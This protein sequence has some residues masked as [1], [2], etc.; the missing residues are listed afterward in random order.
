MEDNLLDNNKLNLKDSKESE[1]FEKSKK[2]FNLNRTLIVLVFGLF[3]LVFFLAGVL[4]QEKRNNEFFTQT[5]RSIED[6]LESKDDGKE[7]QPVIQQEEAVMRVVKEV[8]P[9]V[10]SIV[11][12]KD[13]PVLRRRFEIHG[14]L[15]KIPLYEE[16]DFERREIGGGSGFI[17][18]SQGLILTNRHVVKEEEAEYTVFTSDGKEYK[19][20]VIARDPVQ[21]LAIMEIKE[22]GNFSTVKL[23]SSSNA[24]IGQTVVAIGNAL[25]EFR[26][27]VS[28][29]VVS[30]LGRT[31]TATDGRM[32]YTFEDVI[33]T[34]AAINVG[35]S[36]GPLLNLKGEVI[37]INSAMAIGAQN[38]GFS[39]PI[40][41]AKKMIDN[42]L[43]HGEIVYPFLGVRYLTVNEEVQRR[44]NLPV[45]YGS[46]IIEGDF[47]EPAIDPGSA[48]EK[49]GLR[50]D[51]IILEFDGKKISRENS[52]AQIIL[53]YNPGDK[54]SLKILRNEREIILEA[55]L[56][57][58]SY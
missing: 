47:G 8:S 56:G 55:T 51:D 14:D 21:D 11:V 25:G 45:D 42:F 41:K 36:G 49:A 38:I 15:F 33:Q 35:N 34:D 22:K 16:N 2:N 7:Y 58:K 17:V 39:I 32:M 27:T 24:T 12:S 13:V 6:I 50:K 28:T 18:S 26:N 4:F 9:A 23:G 46:W 1:E 5:P 10:V 53:D 44:N 48:A 57:K 52:L 20:D 43:A 30:G 19:A 31:V 29:G 40:D 3:G 37:G 54:I